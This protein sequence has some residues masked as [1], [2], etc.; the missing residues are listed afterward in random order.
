MK[1]TTRQRLLASTLLIGAASLATPAWAQTGTDESAEPPITSEA[2][3]DAAEQDPGSSGTD[4]AE[5]GESIIVTGSRV[6]RR[7]LTSTSPLTVVQ[8]EEFQL[9]GTVNV[10]GV[11]NTLPQVIPGTTAFSNNPGGGVATL[12]L[13]GLGSQRNLVLVNGRRYMFYS[14]NQITDLNTIPAFLIDSVDVVTGGASAVYGSDALAGV[15]NFHLRN[16]LNGIIAGG[17]YS[18]TEHGDGARYNLYAAIGTEFGDGRG[19]VTIYGEYYNRGDI[20]QDARPFSAFALGDSGGTLIPL[21][22]S[23]VPQGRH[24]AIGSGSTVVGAGTNYQ[25]GTFGAFFGNPGVSTPYNSATDSYNYAP[26]NYLMVPQKRWTL[27]GYGEYELIDNIRAYGEVAFVNN[28]V[29]NELA[30]TPI[31]QRV[32]IPLSIAC[33]RVSAADCTQLTNIAAQQAALIAGGST[34]YGPFTAGAGSFN[35]LQP[36]EVAITTNYRVTQIANRLSLDDRNGYRMLGGFRGGITDDINFDLYYSYARTKNAQ[37]QLGNISRSR[38]VTN[39]ENGT[40]NVFGANLLSQTCINNISIAAQNQVESRLQ[41]AQ[42]SISGSAP[43]TFPWANDAV[44][45]A[46]GAEWRSMDARFIPDTALS[47]GDVA[48]FNAGRPTSGQYDAKELFAELRL[49]IVQD[50]FIHRF[51]LSGAYRYSDYSLEAVGGVHTYAAGAELAPVQDVTFRAQYQRAVRAPNVGELFGGQS[52]GFPAATDP[53]SSRQPVALRT[54]QL[55]ALCIATGVPA[56][57]VW[58][59]AIQPNAQIEGRFGGNPL[60]Q[61]EVGDTYTVGAIIRPRFVPRLNVAIDWYDIKVANAISAAGGGAGGILD[62]C[63]NITM[64]GPICGLIRRDAAGSISG[65]GEFII[66]ALNANLSGLRSRGIDW[67]V[68]Y[69]LPVNFG[70]MGPSSKLSFYVVGNYTY[71]SSYTRAPGDPGIQC[72]G[73]F[74]LLCDDPTPKWKWSSR[75][76]WADGPLTTSIRWR[77]LSSVKDDN[78]TIQYVVEKI[79]AYDYFDLAFSFDVTD[80]ATLNLGI[81]NLFDKKPPVIGDN[82]EQANTYPGTYDVLGRDFFVSAQFR[83]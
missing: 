51:E 14:T 56:A 31:T 67:Q 70:L 30:A 39:V 8:D 17:Q 6:P 11:L 20:F 55:Q 18:L 57:N 19:N 35:A 50:N 22:S 54:P 75:V 3:P 74:G 44:G 15:T 5:R 65:G 43:F 16:D 64:G 9:S 48:G 27:G 13:R 47:S 2:D 26:S 61:E 24:V 62:L 4:A 73:R 29:D 34:A 36:G 21:G 28:Q 41:V 40:C 82:Q 79:D 71:D 68:D 25:S 80:N 69:N 45:F 83:L 7:D 66:T 10:E 58:T 72:E 12:N 53:C 77:H 33:A 1:F 78:D 46:V 59:A 81:N 76:S 63:Y 52:I 23:G 37:V 42:G 32:Y 49:P 38:Y 60:L